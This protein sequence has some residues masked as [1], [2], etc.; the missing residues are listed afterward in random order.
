VKKLLLV[1]WLLPLLSFAS[2][3]DFIER[4][5]PILDTLGP[6]KLLVMA[7]VS[8]ESNFSSDAYNSKTFDYSWFQLNKVH[9]PEAESQGLDIVNSP[10]DNFNFGL[11]L[12]LKNGISP[13]RASFSCI[14]SYS[15]V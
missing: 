1:L 6:T 5:D 13:W 2:K 3:Q 10:D 12:L 15:P 7:I 8:C 9:I 14:G 11:S 4:Y